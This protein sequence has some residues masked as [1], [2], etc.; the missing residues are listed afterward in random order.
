[1]D[2]RAMMVIVLVLVAFPTSAGT[3]ADDLTGVEVT[4]TKN[5]WIST[6]I[7]APPGDLAH[8]FVYLIQYPFVSDL[9]FGFLGPGTTSLIEQKLLRRVVYFGTRI[10][11]VGYDRET[12]DT[13]AI[14]L[15]TWS[16]LDEYVIWRADAAVAGCVVL[17]PRQV[18]RIWAGDKTGI[19][20]INKLGILQESHLETLLLDHLDVRRKETLIDGN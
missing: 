14:G 5:P 1:M 2:R 18:L 16:P 13:Y 8:P 20:T 4:V 9:T 10:R 11:I 15:V 3:R 7:D 6:E 12:A 17:V 19:D